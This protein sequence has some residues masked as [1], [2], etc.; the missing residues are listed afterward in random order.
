MK[1]VAP[2]RKAPPGLWSIRPESRSRGG[3]SRRGTALRGYIR[4]SELPQ[5][6]SI[7]WRWRY[8][9]RWRAGSV[10]TREE[11]EE[12]RLQIREALARGDEPPALPNYDL[13]DERRAATPSAF[14][15]AELAERRAA[16]QR[17]LAPDAPRC[18]VCLMLSP[19]SPCITEIRRGMRS[20]RRA[21]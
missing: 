6:F 20:A 11:A 1:A 9:V 3:G 16:L 21:E 14:T 4:V 8:D 19:C 7:A 18:P 2:S 10:R 13:R 5:S 17:Q 12:L 15:P